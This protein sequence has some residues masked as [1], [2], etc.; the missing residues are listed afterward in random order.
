VD[1]ETIL[2]HKALV[3]QF[4][5]G[6]EP[7]SAASVAGT[8]QLLKEGVIDK[9]DKVA[10]ILTGHMLKDPDSTVKYHTGVDIK[11]VQ[12]SAPRTPPQ[13]KQ[14]NPPIKVLDDLE[15]IITALQ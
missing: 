14:S 7:A 13:G 10:C 5:F 2:E 9:N 6:C 12:D 3:G 4:G 11:A 8:R 15:S 1:D